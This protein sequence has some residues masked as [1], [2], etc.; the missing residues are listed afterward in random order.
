MDVPF[1]LRSEKMR[2]FIEQLV[3]VSV[4]SSLFFF[5]MSKKNFLFYFFL[6]S[7]TV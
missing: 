4:K 3:S 2:E 6:F 1:L 5:S 7:D